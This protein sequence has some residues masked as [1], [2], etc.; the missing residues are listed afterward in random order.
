MIAEE[1][2]MLNR[3]LAAL[4]RP[5]AMLA[6]HRDK[7][8]V[9]PNG[10]RRRRPQ[11]SLTAVQTRALESDGALQ[12]H[13]DSYVLTPAGARRAVRTEARDGEQFL[14]QHTRIA[15]RARINT[16][17]MV[18]AVRAAESGALARLAA[19]RNPG[20]APWLAPEELRAARR[21]RDVWLAGQIGLVRGSDWS[22]PPRGSTARA[23][24]GEDRLIASVDARR[25][26]EEALARLAP[27]LRRVA[28]RVCL[29]EAAFEEIEAAEAWPPR[30]AKLALK[31]ALAQLAA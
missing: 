2:R 16:D 17:G 27:S 20:G 29:Q 10:D 1:N 22:A 26:V 14:A 30:T 5:G 13:G 18:E 19:L 15:D 8:G 11:A 12:R 3:A 23:A 24:K 6:P 7:F 28:E 4:A 31:L 21:L 25:R 9:F